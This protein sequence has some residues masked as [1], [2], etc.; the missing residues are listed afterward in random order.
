MLA[1]SHSWKMVPGFP[2]DDK[3]PILSLDCAIKFD[4]GRVIL[5]HIDHIFEASEGVIDFN[6]LHFSR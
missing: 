6:N 1:G 4:T 3:L 5:E 2:I